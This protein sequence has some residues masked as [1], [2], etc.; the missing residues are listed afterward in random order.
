MEE[1]IGAFPVITP[2]NF[3]DKNDSLELVNALNQIKKLQNSLSDYSIKFVKSYLKTA[4]EVMEYIP[5]SDIKNW[6][7][8]PEQLRLFYSNEIF[9]RVSIIDILKR[10]SGDSKTYFINF[11]KKEV[12]LF[13]YDKAKLKYET[14]LNNLNNPRM[15]YSNLNPGIHNEE[16]VLSVSCSIAYD[17]VYYEKTGPMLNTGYRAGR[18]VERIRTSYITY[19]HTF[20]LNT[21][22]YI[23]IKKIE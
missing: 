20:C 2:N 16:N 21:N 14:G 3:E 18:E 17:Y 6:K 1:T 15:R 10:I 22:K 9:E 7:I 8:L 12:N 13:W 5:D 19:I 4:N 11:D 23:G